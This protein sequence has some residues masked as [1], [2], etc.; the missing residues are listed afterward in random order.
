M[1]VVRGRASRCVLGKK[2]RI[3]G[4]AAL[5]SSREEFVKTLPQIQ[6][7][8]GFVEKAVAGCV[9]AETKGRR[10]GIE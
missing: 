1:P 9:L 7:R 5:C 10:G 2:K 3:R 6:G 4:E 8:R